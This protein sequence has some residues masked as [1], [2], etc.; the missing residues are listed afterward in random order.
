MPKLEITSQE[1]S[2]LRAAAHPLRPVVL[3]GDRGLSD[4]VLKEIDLNLN[5]HQLIK[6]RIAGEEREARNAMLETICES[7]SC[8]LVHHLGKTLIIYRPDLAAQK[9]KAETENATRAIRKPSEPHTPKKL[10]AEGVTRTRRSEKTK[11]AAQKAEKPETAA[12]RARRASTATTDRPAHGIPRRSGSALSL[13]A[14]ARRSAA[15]SG[16]R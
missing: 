6:V 16:K 11:R 3:I 8:A 12:P 5:A 13:R 2:A 9:A 7:L 10:A 4:S 14:G 15:R 1:R